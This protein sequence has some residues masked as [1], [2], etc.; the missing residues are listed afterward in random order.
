MRNPDG[1]GVVR[2]ATVPSET[3]ELPFQV[4][5]V[6]AT[7]GSK[8]VRSGGRL[9]P[10]AWWATETPDGPGTLHLDGRGHHVRA[11]AW[12]PGAAWLLRQAPRLLGAE[13]DPDSFRPGD[14]PLS[15]LARGK[16]VRFGRSDRVFEALLPT[17]LGQKVQTKAAYE[18]LRRI[19]AAHGEPAPG[20]VSL[21][22]FPTAERV[23]TLGYADFHRHNVERKRAATIIEAARRA[24][25]LEEI[26]DLSTE[27]A[28]RRLQAVRGIGPWSAALVMAAACGDADA[29]PVGDYHIPHS[30]AWVL[31]GEPRGTDERML[32]LLEPYRGHR[33]RVIRLIKSSGQRAPRYGPKLSIIDFTAR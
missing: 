20:P 14:G 31:A 1:I 22:M 24:S 17:I 9:P 33:M 7:R 29:V 16:V 21:R 32:E 27:D 10:G 28:W 15:A 23:A 25:R 18:S 11:E 13:D 4:D 6:A 12:G 8:A 5:V 2:S 3:I 30:V 26:V 19:V